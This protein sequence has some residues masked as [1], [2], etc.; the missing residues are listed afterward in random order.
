MIIDIVPLTETISAEVRGV[1]LSW[2]KAPEI[3]AKLQSAWHQF[4]WK[5]AKNGNPYLS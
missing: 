3:A 2:P 1:D 5:L 4:A